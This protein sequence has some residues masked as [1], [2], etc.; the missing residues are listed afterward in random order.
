MDTAEQ[1]EDGCYVALTTDHLVV[2]PIM[3]RVRSP[4]AGAIVIFAGTSILFITLYCS[5]PSLTKPNRHHKRQLCGQ[6]R[7]GAPVFGLP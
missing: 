4:K 1:V 7:Q 2:Q 6:A 5:S 3:D